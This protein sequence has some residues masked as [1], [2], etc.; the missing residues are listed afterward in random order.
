[1]NSKRKSYQL[2]KRTKTQSGGKLDVPIFEQ[3]YFPQHNHGKA[4]PRHFNA[5][6]EAGR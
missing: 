6:K 5:E 2:V 1:M 3:K 4:K